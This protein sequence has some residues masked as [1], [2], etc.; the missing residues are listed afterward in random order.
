[1]SALLTLR[2]DVKPEET[3]DEVRD[4]LLFI[5]LKFQQGAEPMETLQEINH[6]RQP[7]EQL[8]GFNRAEEI[9]QER[10]NENE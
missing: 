3:Y 1:M 7:M 8:K 10:N 2:E 4:A 5:S 6:A 9:I